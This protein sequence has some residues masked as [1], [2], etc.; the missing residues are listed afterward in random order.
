MQTLYRV[1]SGWKLSTD[2]SV[3]VLWEFVAQAQNH[4][5]KELDGR[6]QSDP[7]GE[8]VIVCPF[9]SEE[10]QVV[11]IEDRLIPDGE[12]PGYE[13]RDYVLRKQNH[14]STQSAPR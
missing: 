10:Q 13:L 5:N 4:G 11:D 1:A 2:V 6:C 3:E 8:N 14:G 9:D 12:R 7:L